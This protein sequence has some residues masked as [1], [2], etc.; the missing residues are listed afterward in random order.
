MKVFSV[1]QNCLCLKHFN[2]CCLDIEICK[3]VMKKWL[4]AVLL[5]CI[6]LLFFF[7]LFVSPCHKIDRLSSQTV[8]ELNPGKHLIQKLNFSY[9]FKYVYSPIIAHNNRHYKCNGRN[10]NA[11]RTFAYLVSICLRIRFNTLI[12]NSPFNQSCFPQKG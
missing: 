8:G 10:G 11:N 1:Y 5:I 6:F 2:F 9:R 7:F 4:P 12:W 3:S